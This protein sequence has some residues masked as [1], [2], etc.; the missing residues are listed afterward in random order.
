MPGDAA[1]AHG[2]AQP[3]PSDAAPS[4]DNTPAEHLP[5]VPASAPIAMPIAAPSQRPHL[6]VSAPLAAGKC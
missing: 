1:C 3:A 6:H 4:S 2:H 5:A